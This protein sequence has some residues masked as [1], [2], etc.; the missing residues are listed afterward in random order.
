[1]GSVLWF[2]FLVLFKDTFRRERSATYQMAIQRAKTAALKRRNEQHEMKVA[3][4]RDDR[5]KEE[6]AAPS[7]SVTPMITAEDVK[8]TLA[9]VNP[10]PPLLLVLKR[11]NNI[12]ILL[13]SGSS[14]VGD[15]GANAHPH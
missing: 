9:D 5:S 3:A 7:G 15:R 1:L 12:S 10:F 2:A 14:S 11:K 6:S 8:L 13:P 4:M